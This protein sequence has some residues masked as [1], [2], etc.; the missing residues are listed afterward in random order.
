MLQFKALFYRSMNFYIEI[1]NM[2]FY[3]T[4]FITGLFFLFSPYSFAGENGKGIG[5]TLN[6]KFDVEL[7]DVPEAVMTVI[8]NANPDF[9]MQEAEKEFKHGNTYFDI[10]G[11]DAA[12]NEVEFDMLLQKDGS[13]RIAEIQRDVTLEQCPVAV[14]QLFQSSVPGVSPARIIE[15][16]QGDGVVIYEFYTVEN[17]LERK[18]EIKMQVELLDKEWKH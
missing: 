13:W 17:K 5:S 7:T 3:K 18:Y 16:D 14:S 9:K 10:E 2:N 11:F 6:K 8:R 1:I 4:V 12:G 15:S